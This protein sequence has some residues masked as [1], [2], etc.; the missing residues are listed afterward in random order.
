[1]NVMLAVLN[2]QVTKSMWYLPSSPLSEPLTVEADLLILRETKRED[3]SLQPP[4]RLD[5]SSIRGLSLPP[6]VIYLS[7]L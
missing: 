3:P 1:M 5:K 7:V 6:Q 4:K 2:N